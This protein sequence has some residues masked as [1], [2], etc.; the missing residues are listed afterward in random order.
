MTT[1]HEHALVLAREIV[2]TTV[3]WSPQTDRDLQSGKNDNTAEVRIALT[4]ILR[5]SE[6]AV[7]LLVNRRCY[8]DRGEVECGAERRPTRP[9][10]M[11][12]LHGSGG[13]RARSSP[14]WLVGAREDDASRPRRPPAFDGGGMMR[15]NAIN[16]L[17]Q[18]AGATSKEGRCYG[19]DFSLEELARHLAQVRD[20]EVPVEEF[21][22]FYCLTEA[23]RKPS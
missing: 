6:L 13:W 17:R 12:V 16:M 15:C 18:A 3:H 22:Q 10:F 4:A 9:V 14:A 21:L 5:T 1:L 19:Y 23:D 20:G 7:Q 8:P 11:A 2:E